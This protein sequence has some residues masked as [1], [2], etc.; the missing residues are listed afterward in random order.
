VLTMKDI[1]AHVGVSVSTVSLVLNDRDAGRVR[2]DIAERVRRAA[3]EM[4]YVPNLLARGLKTRQTSTIGLVSDRVA[5][6]PFASQMLAGAQVASAE[7]GYLL[8]LIDTAG[9]QELESPAVKALLQRNIEGLIVAAE[10]HRDVDLPLVPESVPVV[11]L[12]GRPSDVDARV[13]WVVPDEV[14]GAFAA[15]SYLIRAGHKRIAFCNVSNSVFVARA[16]RQRGYET[17]LGEAGVT[18]DPSL[19]VEADEPSASAG[20]V[21]ALKLLQRPDRPTAVFCFSDQIAFGFYQAAHH[22]GLEIPR[23]VSIV[24]F[25]NRQFVADS[26]FPGLS[27]IQ[28]PHR[29]M[30][31]WAA[32]QIIARSR[33]TT[34]P[35]PAHRLMPCPVVERASVAP[36][37]THARGRVEGLAASS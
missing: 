28:L 18:L 25:D 27:T 31:A 33:G 19:I 21:S 24:G 34:D 4:G 16:L 13:D 30:G 12:D 20:R 32:K 23:D 2:A 17:A 1:A 6:I 11:I 8:L 9:N 35:A 7:D 36:P 10:F 14:G 5:S 29:E 15:T 22:L 26:L 3:D 37:A